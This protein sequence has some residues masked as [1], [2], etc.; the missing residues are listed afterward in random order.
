MSKHSATTAGKRATTVRRAVSPLMMIALAGSP[1]LGSVAAGIALAPAASAAV[2]SNVTT[3]SATLVSPAAGATITPGATIRIK[4]DWSVPAG[5]KSGDTMPIT[6][7]TWLQAQVVSPVDIKDA[8]GN[9]IGTIAPAADPTKGWVV[10]Y[11]DYVDTHSGVSASATVLATQYQW[12]IGSTHEIT[13]TVGGKVVD[14]GATLIYQSGGWTNREITQQ[15]T[16]YSNPPSENQ[17]EYFGPSAVDGPSTITA[18]AGTGTFYNC[19]A[20]ESGTTPIRAQDVD[21][22]ATPPHVRSSTDGGGLKKVTITSCTAD[23]ITFTIASTEAGWGSLVEIPAQLTAASIQNQVTTF[24][25]FSAHIAFAG[26]TKDYSSTGSYDWGGASGTGNLLPIAKITAYIDDAAP[27]SPSGKTGSGAD[28]DANTAPGVDA[29]F[30]GSQTVSLK[31][32]NTGAVDWTSAKVV[33]SKGNT[34]VTLGAVAAGSATVKTFAVVL[35]P[36]ETFSETYTLTA[37]AA[38]GSTTS[39]DPVNAHA[40]LPT[41]T[42]KPDTATTPYLT[43]VT[44]DV[45]ANDTTNDSDYPLDAST[46]TLVDGSGDPVDSITVAG[47]GVYSVSGGKIVFTPAAGFVGDAGAVKYAVLDELGTEASSTVQVTVTNV[48]PKAVDD[49]A[50]TKQNTPVTIDVLGNDS[51]GSKAD[52]LVPSTLT[53]LDGS[54][55]PAASVTVDGKGTFTVSGGKV[56]FTPAKNYYGDVPAVSYQV[57]DSIKNVTSAKVVVTVAQSAG[58][59][60]VD[61]TATTKQGVAVTLDTLANDKAG[62]ADLD[63]STLTLLDASGEAVSSIT[64]AGQGTYSVAGGKVTFTPVKTFHGSADKVA[65]RIADSNGNT[66]T[67]YESVT[68]SQGAGPAAVNDTAV[69]KQDTPVTIDVLANDKAADAPLVPSTLTLLDASGKAV[70]SLTIAGKGTF[71]VADGKVVFTPV[72]GFYGDVPVVKYQVGDENG[73]TATATIAVKVTQSVP[74]VPT[75]EG[76]S[77]EGSA[78]GI[79]GGAAAAVLGA[80]GFGGMAVR[81]RRQG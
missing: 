67:A 3:A 58:P 45:L 1:V 63:P 40:A 24:P 29:G 18:K 44:V 10:T 78:A 47:K 60:A 15:N 68:V 61:D 77:T 62:D 69:T 81:K 25:G 39:A 8:A 2:V 56:V 11:S 37:V 19:A 51:G 9:V 35:D 32:Q 74:V 76:A 12:V 36:G 26:G 30:G 73:N 80:L 23:S 65:Y 13:G 54:G 41:P 57:A 20:I 33:D 28:S 52:P 7:P 72:K 16:R 5:A 17:S 79:V 46:L 66:A 27:A 50:S 14:T 75:G 21:V 43:P 49:A 53:L 55:K 34:V 31:I 38:S 4:F 59:V 6:L 70:S 48:L 42:A 64:V 22:T 71:T